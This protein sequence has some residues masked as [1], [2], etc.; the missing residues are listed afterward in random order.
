[1]LTLA[2]GELKRLTFDD[3]LDQ[4]DA[5]SRD[6]RWI[7]F[8]DGTNDVWRKNDIY[9]VRVEG[10]TPMAVSADRFTNEFQG[11]PSPDGRTLAMAA[12]GVGDSQWWRN[13]AI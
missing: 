7:Y 10:G 13:T 3:G 12:R 9:R 11:A 1:M 2:S 4:L 8:S 5:W 6:G